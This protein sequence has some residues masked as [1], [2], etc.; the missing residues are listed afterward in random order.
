MKSYDKK[1]TVWL[2]NYKTAY[3]YHYIINLGIHILSGC[4]LHQIIN[5]MIK[6]WH[7]NFLEK[8][9]DT[10]LHKTQNVEWKARMNLFISHCLKLP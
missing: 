1:H 7:I 6:T 4:I 3:K 2:N 8:S 10:S 9:Q 5:L